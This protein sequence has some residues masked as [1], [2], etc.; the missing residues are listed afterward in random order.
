M[1]PNFIKLLRNSTHT[2]NYAYHPNWS[3]WPTSSYPYELEEYIYATHLLRKRQ[4]NTENREYVVFF[5]LQSPQKQNNFRT[6]ISVSP[7]RENFMKSKFKRLF[8]IFC[9][10]ISAP[11]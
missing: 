9:E 6:E 5:V 11:W 2:Q 4:L 10:Y 8:A 3:I 1:N 7:V